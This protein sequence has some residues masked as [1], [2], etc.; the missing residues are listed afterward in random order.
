MVIYLYICAFQ[1]MN[2]SIQSSRAKELEAHREAE[3]K[4]H[5]LLEQTAAA[6][7]ATY[8]PCS[9]IYWTASAQCFAASAWNVSNSTSWDPS[10][11]SEIA[12]MITKGVS[13]R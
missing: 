1:D 11:L 4:Q 12:R 13:L 5:V 3:R 2:D 6:L 8:R 9:T 10:D 7:S